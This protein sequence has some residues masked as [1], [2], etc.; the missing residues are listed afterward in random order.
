LEINLSAGKTIE[1]YDT[2]KIRFSEPV[3]AL[4]P[5]Q[6]HFAQKIDTTWHTRLFPISQDEDDPLLYWVAIPPKYGIEYRLQIDSAAITSVYYKWNNTVNATFKFQDKEEYGQ[7]YVPMKGIDAPGFGELLNASDQKVKQAP[8]LNGELEFPD[9]QPGKYYL[10]FIVDTNN[11][12]KWDTGDYE[13]N[14]LPETVYYYPGFFEVRKNWEQDLE[15]AWNPLEIPVEKQKPIEITK[16]KP[17][18]KKKRQNESTTTSGS[19]RT[20]TGSSSRT[21]SSPGLGGG[22]RS[23]PR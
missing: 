23:L 2:L 22:Q 18:E 4:D 6:L 12:G 11:D 7:L 14:L 3:L 10:R 1:V 16:N 8:L 15:R 13:N 19:S 9:L 5:D 21:N 20:S 17:A